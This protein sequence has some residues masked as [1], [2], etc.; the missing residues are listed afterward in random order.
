MAIKRDYYEVLGLPRNASE[1]EIKRAFRKLAFQYHRDHNKDPN[2]EEKFKEINEA[3]Q[4]L[5]NPEKRASYDRYGHVVTEGGQGFPDFGFGGLGDIF[6][7]FFNAFG[8]TSFG[9]ATHHI[10]RKG[11]NLRT[12]LTISF[13][14]AVFGCQKEVEIRRIEVCPMCHGTGCRPGTNPRTCPECQG[15]GQ[16]RK[17]QRSIFG[18]F[19]HITACPRCSGS[20][21][22]ITDPCFQCHGEGRIRTKRKL[23]VGIPAGVDDNYQLC[24]NSEGDAGLYGG[25]SG[26]LY[27]HFSIKPHNLFH[28]EGSDILY[29]LPI[30]FAQAALGDEIDIP[31]L[32]GKVSLKIPPGTQDGKVFRLKG[33]G[34]LYLNGKGKGDQLVKIQI[35]TPQHLDG[36]QRRLFQELAEILPKAKL[37]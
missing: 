13:E 16:V 31:A 32:D 20:G 30:N 11:E 29:E 33:K 25:V 21:T 19:S 12:H 1:E 6:E 24:L 10:P 9:R 17:Y 23:T 4:V 8:E 18:H 15:K 5:S 37:S 35:V 34:I 22:I 27:V 3:Y 14:E 2:A 26:D 28:R 7:S 36:N